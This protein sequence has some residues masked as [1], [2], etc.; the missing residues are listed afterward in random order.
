MRFAGRFI[1]LSNISFRRYLAGQ[2]VSITGT[3]M[4]SVAQGWVM[5]QLTHS[6]V[7]LAAVAVTLT[8]PSFFLTLPAGWLAD[9]FPRRAILI[10]TQALLM[11]PA[12]LLAILAFSDALRVWHLMLLALLSGTLNAVEHPARH[13]LLGSMV[14][15]RQLSSAVALFSV[16]FNASRVLGSVIAGFVIASFGA[17]ICFLLNALSS[18]AAIVSLVMVQSKRGEAEKLGTAGS[19]TGAIQEGYRFIAGRNDILPVMV[20]VAAVSL[21]GIPFIP[22]LPIYS[23]EVLNVGAAGLGL[24][25][26]ATGA[27]SLVAALFVLLL[28][29]TDKKEQYILMASAVFGL[30]LLF[31]AR[32]EQYPLT[33][34][35][36]LLVGGGIVAILAL[37]SCIIQHATP[38]RLRGRVMGFY[39]MSLVGLTPVGH[40]V[41]G[42]L[43]GRYGAVQ[44]LSIG[45]FIC[46]LATAGAGYRIFRS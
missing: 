9:R 41:M 28:G 6:A 13:A 26:G 35:L 7:W 34:F 40:G 5:Y 23:E 14:R 11:V 44:A 2:A 32:S 24:M 27:G 17:P 42:M 1:S 22:L 43:A 16:V 46:I 25:G 10:T 36:L 3:C 33:L 18:L 21:F 12:L 30:G 29:D 37:A 20:L 4:Q 45:A 39:S 19:I 8:A 38:D 31:F 15:K